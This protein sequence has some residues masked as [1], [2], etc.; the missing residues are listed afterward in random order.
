MGVYF[1][2][3]VSLT[4]MGQ[5]VVFAQRD[6]TGDGAKDIYFNVLDLKATSSNDCFDWTGFK[7]V[8]FTE[9]L[10][11]VGMSLITLDET[12]SFHITPADA[13]FRV[14]SDE[15]YISI[16]RQS[17]DNTLYVNRFT[18]VST[19]SRRDPD[20]HEFSLQPAWEVRFER[21]GKEDVPA[22]AK[23]TQGYL[24]PEGKPF[25]EPTLELAMVSEFV[26]G[27]FDV[28]LLPV[29]DSSR[30]QW[31][32]TVLNSTTQKVD[33]YTLPADGNGLFDLTGKAITPSN[34]IVPDK[35]FSVK[36]ANGS[37]TP[38]SV[39]QAPA[40]SFYTKQE[41]VVDVDGQS[42]S[43]KRSGRFMI[44]LAGTHGGTA[45]TALVDASVSTLG[46]LADIPEDLTASVI[47]EANYTLAYNG[48]AYVGLTS[49][50][51]NPLEIKGAFGFKLWIYPEAATAGRR[52]IVGTINTANEANSAPYLALVDGA[53]LE[54]GFGDGS[55]RIS[56]RTAQPLISMNNW[57]HVVVDYQGKGTHP[58]TLTI[59]NSA[60]P[61]TDVTVS[62]EPM[63]TAL[64]S[65]GAPQDGF[66]G[67]IDETTLLVGGN[68][69]CT[70]P[71][72]DVDYTHSPPSTPNTVSGATVEG[73]VF[74]ATLAPSNCPLGLNTTGELVVDENN[75]TIYAG[76]A[77]FLT[78]GASPFLME[79]SDGLLHLY[80]GNGTASDFA[81]AHYALTTSRSSFYGTWQAQASG[82]DEAGMVSF[83]ASR[84]GS[85]FNSAT[86]ALGNSFST[87]HCNLTMA[88]QTSGTTETWTGVPRSL[89]AFVA[90]L[91]GQ[92]VSSPDDGGLSGGNSLFFD[93]N[94][95]H[96]GV[97]APSSHTG[98][99]EDF[100]FITRYAPELPLGS[101]EVVD[102][103]ASQ[104]GTVNVNL[105]INP[106]HWKNNPSGKQIMTQAWGAIP[107]G[108][109]EFGDVLAGNAIST[110]DY[111]DPNFSNCGVVSLNASPSLKAEASNLLT[112]FSQ[113]SAFTDF[114]MAV[115]G[116]DQVTCD[117][118]ITAGGTP[119]AF[120]GVS[121]DQNDLVTLVNGGGAHYP[122]GYLA[123]VAPFVLAVSDGLLAQVYNQI[124]TAPTD[125]KLAG[126]MLFSQFFT[127]NI[128]SDSRVV[129]LA[130]TTASV[131]QG[132]KRSK[133]SKE[134]VL[135]K[136]SELFTAF[137][138]TAPTNGGIGVVQNS[139]TAPILTLGADGGWIK[140]P[141]RFALDFNAQSHANH[142]A[143]DV[144]KAYMPSEHLAIA[145]DLS[146]EAWGQPIP[147]AGGETLSKLLNHNV[148]GNVDDPGADFQYMM[149]YK[150][151]HVP[152]FRSSA[153]V[154]TSIT[155]NDG[156]VNDI[157]L[158][159]FVRLDSSA[160]DAG[161]LFGLSTNLNVSEYLRVRAD[162]YG[163]LDAYFTGTKVAS[164][165][166]SMDTWIAVGLTLRS[167]SDTEVEAILYVDGE[168]KG[169][170]TVT[171]SFSDQLG[172]LFGGDYLG[173]DG[174]Q[175]RIN[176]L[177]LWPRALDPLAMKRLAESGVSHVV[178]PPLICLNL[179]DGPGTTVARN[180]SYLGLDY[181]G[182]YMNI[183]DSSWSYGGGL[184]VSPF[185]SNGA[186][187][188]LAM[189]TGS[190]SWTHSAFVFRQGFSLDM[191][192]NNYVDC[193]NHAS[194]KIVESGSLEAWVKPSDERGSFRVIASRNGSYT[195]GLYPDG[196]AFFDLATESDGVAR[197]VTVKASTAIQ[198][199]Q[200]G[201]LAV[202]SE[203]KSTQPPYEEGKTA[204]PTYGIYLKLYVNGVL[205]STFTKDD[206]TKPVQTVE[207]DA[208]L[209][210]C[211]SPDANQIYH[212]QIGEVR[213][214]NRI[215]GA[216]E[217]TEVFTTHGPPKNGDGLISYWRFSEMKGQTAFDSQDVNN[218]IIT[219][220]EL[221]ALFPEIAT[222]LFYVDGSLSRAL[223]TSIADLGGYGDTDAFTVGT[224]LVSGASTHPM[225]G[226]VDEVRVW[227]VQL[228]GEQISDSM[229]RT[230]TGSE[231]GLAAYWRFDSGS[232][233]GV[234]DQ[235]GR[236]N[237]GTFVP[238]DVTTGPLWMVS[239]APIS[240]E[241]PVV[242]NALGG[243]RTLNLAQVSGQPSVL[244]YSD[245]QVNAYGDVFSVMKRAYI[246]VDKNNGQQVLATGFK[247][248]DLD[249]I[250][251]GQVQ[252]NPSIIGFI[253]GAPPLPSENQTFPYW[254]FSNSDNSN[255][256]SAT[257]VS[258]AE[259]SEVVYSFSA[260]QVD[261]SK[262][263]ISS[264]VGVVSEGA[265]KSSVGIGVEAG[266]TLFEYGISGGVKSDMD[267]DTSDVK[268]S[269]LENHTSV[270]K[271]SGFQPGGSW[272][273][274]T[275]IVNSAVGLRFI[276]DN[277][278]VAI[279]KSGTADLYMLAIKGT[280][281]P[282]RYSVVPNQDI[283]EDMN[284]IPFPINN[285]YI[286][287]GTLDG[288]IGL[289]NDPDYPNANLV[290]GSYFK[291][292]E[293]YA[294]KRK[295]ERTEK[296]LEGF[297]EQFNTSGGM[298]IED[299]SGKIENNPA[300][301]WGRKIS[302][303][304]IVNTY[305]WSSSGATYAEQTSVMDTYTES[306]SGVEN[307]DTGFGGFAEAKI[308]K[309]IGP[310]SE[311]DLMFN[312]RLEKT[313]TKTK[314]STQ[315]FDLS[316]SAN[317]ESTLTAPIVREQ[318]G[319]P[320]LEG[321]TREL[322]PGKVDG[323]RYLAFYMT[324]SEENFQTLFGKV[325]D[326]HWM[327]NSVD[328][329]AVALRQASISENGCWRILYRVTFVSRI[330]AKFQ[331]V[332]SET[333]PPNIDPPANLGFNVWLT[334]IV[335]GL[336]NKEKP[337]TEEVGTAVTQTLGTSGSD[338]GALGSVLPWWPGFL[339]ASEIYGS[340]EY[341]ALLGLR[342][343]L[344]RYM[345][346]K[347]ESEALV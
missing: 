10:R 6:V 79:G 137:A 122:T 285:K 330:P 303:R 245:I 106:L 339:T 11:P 329:N 150:N 187:A 56:C 343:D 231:T 162:T 163:K 320:Q 280:R 301:D 92:A 47:Q 217:V 173:H 201:Y 95:V 296:E 89:D 192:D 59:N 68:E 24:S 99:P 318:G 257:S 96:P 186:E 270:S 160:R 135:L 314:A 342:E 98:A 261:G 164:A 281:T 140:E 168:A 134:M 317:A 175:M 182:K 78:P 309:P 260:N 110:Y 82:G 46:T 138:E 101:V 258:M 233:L 207:T 276:T 334:Q 251:V 21:S 9:Q 44:A 123:Q 325:I 255:Y 153:F 341:K 321:T 113:T 19:A 240:N 85:Y 115:S 197:T 120:T 216:E 146:L 219:S 319:Q 27:R 149:G 157:T 332:K 297:Y 284:L 105:E 308:N 18:L 70:F 346:E 293:A 145:G 158:H 289:E 200:S 177:G 12:D 54:V 3:L 194:L 69:V 287:Q 124:S 5:V 118:T 127:G 220:G 161:D 333:Q 75:L 312:V 345:I 84:A 155:L 266:A 136:G 114:S 4:Y 190:K 7:P 202:T 340:K 8:V 272:E 250:Y 87:A 254:N 1:K 179:N 159:G 178:N 218:A 226:G 107:S 58:F 23:D 298:T 129:P 328:A 34:R 169:N 246:Y 208:S 111:S 337:T 2:N 265:V 43:L 76:V 81:V 93:Y 277:A 16:F 50:S 198:G 176:Q 307:L 181:D 151:W 131:E 229:N 256:A 242:Y 286:K 55:Q 65:I 273:S 49:A 235:T 80:Y 32:F 183:D 64:A 291:P 300:F 41:K 302:N 28:S 63:G 170:S 313:A 268:E 103:S 51:P 38:F 20:V 224:S 97:W 39:T 305:V 167:V 206:Y 15:K 222:T 239:D 14:A 215:L 295:I 290:R 316:C 57:F 189:D 45:A 74:G 60:V 30:Y 279:V 324:P 37:T 154:Y 347:Y 338:V 128:D 102:N 191:V 275:E 142:V 199:G 299:F 213:F 247:V 203:I 204:T 17:M 62:A 33:L 253:E 212:G 100:V 283:P 292:I 209:Y 148:H 130:K 77:D 331:P 248:G 180:S 326:P 310:L 323:Y 26:E 139:A 237:N 236:G 152:S 344:L 42:S 269:S 282:V 271:V 147:A 25:L 22:N 71:F 73:H 311:I 112:I 125:N 267:L 315:S 322:A 88:H 83:L 227:K 144:S 214:W 249:T 109:R 13:P 232:G 35:S 94:G 244:E 91:T 274:I 259:A 61:L 327:N 156:S 29:M 264:K 210:L 171:Q 234:K 230:L 126:A 119:Y 336:V 223:K 86:I 304:N 133:A 263:A 165:T 48:S 52:F 241:S 108:A 121:R 117:V 306:F 278:G 174:M 238:A 288:K 335:E 225:K 90:V 40:A 66:V 188:L 104:Q 141:N 221:W 252:T 36:V 72:S 67:L 185:A 53:I 196:T 243:V 132:A 172:T 205:S 31:Q 143:F 184:F 228:T 294:I 166:V 193:G 116:S 195:L 262:L 211:G